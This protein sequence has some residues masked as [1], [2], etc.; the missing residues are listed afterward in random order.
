MQKTQRT[1][2]KEFKLEAVARDI[3]Q[4]FP[5]HR[6]VYGR[7]LSR[8]NARSAGSRLSVILDLL[9]RMVLGWAPDQTRGPPRHFRVPG[10][11]V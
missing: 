10:A 7:Y 6:Q 3:Q 1:F 2:T 11:L 5:D 9:S 4:L 8:P